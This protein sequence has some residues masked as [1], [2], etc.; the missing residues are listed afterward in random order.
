MSFLSFR[1]LNYNASHSPI[2]S[3]APERNRFIPCPGI[4]WNPRR[5]AKLKRSNDWKR[6]IAD[7]SRRTTRRW[8]K[9]WPALPDRL[10]RRN[11]KRNPKVGMRVGVVGLVVEM[12][13]LR[14]YRMLNYLVKFLSPYFCRFINH[15]PE[16]SRRQQKYVSLVFWYRRSFSVHKIWKVT[17]LGYFLLRGRDN[18]GG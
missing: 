7:D 9:R 4:K 3:F 2:N 10:A 6:N 8:E 13:C 5:S 12:S 18:R 17:H 16:F 1:P 11:S 15:Q 14:Y